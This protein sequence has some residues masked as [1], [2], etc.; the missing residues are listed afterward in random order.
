VVVMLDMTIWMASRMEIL[1]WKMS[2]IIEMNQV[3]TAMI[4]HMILVSLIL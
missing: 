4:G 3:M 1:V 2:L